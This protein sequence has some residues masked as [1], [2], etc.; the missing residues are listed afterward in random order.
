MSQGF[1]AKVASLLDVIK[2]PHVRDR[3]SVVESACRNMCLLQVV[4]VHWTEQGTCPR[5]HA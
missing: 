3:Q 1:S 5:V 4:M 2:V